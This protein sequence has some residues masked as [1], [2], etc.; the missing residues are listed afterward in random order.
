M[1]YFLHEKLGTRTT[2]DVRNLG[3]WNI[4]V[5]FCFKLV[6]HSLSENLRCSPKISFQV[7]ILV[8]HNTDWPEKWFS[9]WTTKN[10]ATAIKKRLA[11][12]TWVWIV[13]TKVHVWKTQSYVR[14]WSCRRVQVT[15]TVLIMRLGALFSS[16]SNS[17]IFSPAFSPLH[18]PQFASV[19]VQTSK[20]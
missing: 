16:S 7:F 15:R 14:R 6:E 9:S 2:P 5:V 1:K 8:M 10:R 17:C 11:V 19:G 20:D 13:S 3:F 12:W 4:S 18:S